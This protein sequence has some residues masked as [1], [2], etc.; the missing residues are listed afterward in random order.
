MQLPSSLD[1][2][3]N[4]DMGA[5]SAAFA[6]KA[7]GSA[8]GAGGGRGASVAPAATR[9]RAG[10]VA[11]GTAMKIDGRRHDRRVSTSASAST[12]VGGK[13][14]SKNATASAGSDDDDDYEVVISS[15]GTFLAIYKCR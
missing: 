9:G 10:A 5:Y 12:S 3:L 2:L 7:E 14:R 6:P 1:D 8:L 13:S 11:G 15:D 4:D